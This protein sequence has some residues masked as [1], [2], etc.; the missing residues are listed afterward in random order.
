MPSA[1]YS[2]RGAG[3]LILAEN[4]GRVLL[5]DRAD[6]RGWSHPGGFV[7]PGE[8][9]EEAAIRELDEE[10]GF[11][12]ALTTDVAVLEVLTMPDGEQALF[13]PGRAPRS[14]F[15]YTVFVVTTRE[16]FSPRLNPEHRAYTWAEPDDIGPHLHPGCALVLAYLRENT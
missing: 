10:T 16:E 15:V 8:A 7:E 13:R 2:K 12:A 9:P 11:P 14:G 1:E 5:L 4:T 3:C 6:G